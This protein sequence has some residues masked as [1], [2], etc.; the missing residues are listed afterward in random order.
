[1]PPKRRAKKDEDIPSTNDV[2]SLDS[3][4]TDVSPPKKLKVDKQDEIPSTLPAT[5]TVTTTT[6]STDEDDDDDKPKC[7]FPTCSLY[8]L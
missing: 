8:D 5:S 6:T 3:A 2:P 7:T 1:M 4:T